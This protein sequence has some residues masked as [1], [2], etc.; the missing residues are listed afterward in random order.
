MSGAIAWGWCLMTIPWH[1]E[2]WDCLR[3]SKFEVEVEVKVG[4]L[5]GMYLTV[6]RIVFILSSPQAWQLCLC[7]AEIAQLQRR[8]EGTNKDQCK[9]ALDEYSCIIFIIYPIF[10]PTISLHSRLLTSRTEIIPKVEEETSHVVR[11]ETIE[12]DLRIPRLQRNTKHHRNNECTIASNC[13]R[14]SKNRTRFFRREQDADGTEGSSIHKAAAQEEIDEEEDKQTIVGVVRGGIIHL[15]DCLDK[16]ALT[17][18]SDCAP[19]DGKIG[20]L[21]TTILVSHNAPHWPVYTSE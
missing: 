19:D 14:P 1:F 17:E 7:S 20:H 16:S 18:S 12:S 13:R 11:S 2:I 9:Q 6:P 4:K 21:G 15:A 10:F 3:R 8:P 5:Y